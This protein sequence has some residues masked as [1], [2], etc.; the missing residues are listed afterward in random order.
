VLATRIRGSLMTEFGKTEEVPSEDRLFLGGAYTVRGYQE[1]TLGPVYSTADS[2]GPGLL[3]DPKGGKALLVGNV[4]FRKN[5]FWRLGGQVFLDL[6][7]LWYEIEHFNLEDLRLTG[8]VG[9]VFFTPVGPLRLD[10]ARRIMTAGD[11]FGGRFHLSI[12]YA[13]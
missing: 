13:F 3:G 8:G 12:L 1:A 7:N 11:S 10:Y 5:L 6:G 9:I 4:E 2:V